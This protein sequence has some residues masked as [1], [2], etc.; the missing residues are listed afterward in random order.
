MLELSPIHFQSRPFRIVSPKAIVPTGVC[1]N[2]FQA[3]PTSLGFRILIATHPDFGSFHNLWS[4][5]PFEL[6]S[7]R[8]LSHLLVLRVLVV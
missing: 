4:V 5:L 1:T 3:V 7:K 2:S 6:G 8:T